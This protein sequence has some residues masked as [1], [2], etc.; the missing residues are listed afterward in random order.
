[1]VEVYAAEETGRDEGA[2]SQPV[3]AHEDRDIEDANSRKTNGVVCVE[4]TSEESKR[5]DKEVRGE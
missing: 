4:N 2:E 5:R 3:R 1:M